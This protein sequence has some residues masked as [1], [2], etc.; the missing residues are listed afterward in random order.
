ML[1]CC[2]GQQAVFSDCLQQC[3]LVDSSHL[4]RSQQQWIIQYEGMFLLVRL[5][6]PCSSPLPHC[7]SLHIQ[8]NDFQMNGN[9]YR[10]NPDGSTWANRYVSLSTDTGTMKFY[11]EKGGYVLISLSMLYS[12]FLTLIVHRKRTLKG[13]VNIKQGRLEVLEQETIGRAFAFAIINESLGAVEDAN[14]SLA[15]PDADLFEQWKTNVELCF[16]IGGVRRRKSMMGSE[17]MLDASASM[18]DIP[19]P[20]PEPVV[21]PE[22]EPAAPAATAVPADVHSLFPSVVEEEPAVP[23]PVAH[24]PAL[25]LAP[26]LVPAAS[27][28]PTESRKSPSTFLFPEVM[29]LDTQDDTWLQPGFGNVTEEEG[30][31]AP[32]TVHTP[33][34]VTFSDTP[35]EETRTSTMDAFR[36]SSLR[37]SF[38]VPTFKNILAPKEVVDEPEP[39]PEPVPVPVPEVVHVEEHTVASTE[40]RFKAYNPADLKLTVR[41]TEMVRMG[42]LYKL[43]TTS[44]DIGEDSW[45]SQ[46]VSLS[47]ATGILEYHAE[48]AGR[49]ILRGKMDVNDSSIK[50][51][52]YVYYGRLFVFKLTR[53]G[54][55]APE[56]SLIFAAEEMESLSY[57]LVS[58]NDC[59]THKDEKEAAAREAATALASPIQLP[60]VDEDGNVRLVEDRGSYTP[61]ARLSV[62]VDQGSPGGGLRTGERPA[63]LRDAAYGPLTEPH[64]RQRAST[65]PA[66]S[67]EEIDKKAMVIHYHRPSF[68]FPSPNPHKKP[69]FHISDAGISAGDLDI[70]PRALSSALSTMSLMEAVTEINETNLDDLFKVEGGLSRVNTMHK[71]VDNDTKVVDRIAFKVKSVHYSAERL[72]RRI[73]IWYCS[74]GFALT[75]EQEIEIFVNSLRSSDDEVLKSFAEERFDQIKDWATLLELLCKYEQKVILERQQAEGED[76]FVAPKSIHITALATLPERSSTVS[77][78]VLDEHFDLE[79]ISKQFSKDLKLSELA[80]ISRLPRVL[81]SKD[82]VWGQGLRQLNEDLTFAEDLVLYQE[83]VIKQMWDDQNLLKVTLGQK[84]DV[85]NQLYSQLSEQ[86]EVVNSQHLSADY[87]FSPLFASSLSNKQAA[88]NNPR[89]LQAIADREFN[90]ADRDGDGR[91]TRE[92]WRGWIADKHNLLSEHNHVKAVLMSEIRN[93]RK[94]LNPNAEQTYQE[95]AKSEEARRK[96]EE[97]LVRLHIEHD[98]MKVIALNCC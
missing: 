94:A 6:V 70:S 8:K 4:R 41:P 69:S 17:M 96:Q 19:V 23:A 34:A 54:G 29:P 71:E 86:A 47:I 58:F 33:S 37:K 95:L 57:W 22:P 91:L 68:E 97:E 21:A 20:A 30:P 77:E 42:Y 78:C 80:L 55:T 14:I 59:R 11:V 24:T 79:A 87:A 88:N 73:R 25:P 9:L 90:I 84:D 7:S 26:A 85:I 89:E 76:G 39:V 49:R 3:V 40:K 16:T 74:S 66:E 43:D 13:Q 32:Q 65:L 81:C 1:L 18:M 44:K 45:I 56:D 10:R 38:K 83:D 5:S 82:H 61:F 53:N 92:E 2:P 28:P 50:T 52:D 12:V 64:G 60:E 46:Y 67:A 93:L 35:T 75:S 36:R 63:A 62:S 98:T 27:V 15:A 31:T 72:A 48:I 51:V